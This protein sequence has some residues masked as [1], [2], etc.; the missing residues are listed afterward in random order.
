[1]F[2]VNGKKVSHL[3]HL[4]K[5]NQ[6]GNVFKMLVLIQLK[7]VMNVVANYSLNNKHVSFVILCR[8]YAVKMHSILFNHFDLV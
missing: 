4:L 6:K 8:T 1:M 2:F 5:E 3:F 7:I